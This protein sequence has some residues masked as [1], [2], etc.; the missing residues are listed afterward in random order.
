MTL[1]EAIALIDAATPLLPSAHPQHWADLGC[2]TGLFT[3]ALTHLLPLQSTVYGVD[4]NPRLRQT[5]HMIPIKA[6][7]VKD[8]LPLRDL[9]GILM[10]NSLH[11]VKDKPSLL[12]KLSACMRPGSPVLI[13]E[14]DTDQA[15]STWV[16]YPVSYASLTKLFITAGYKQVK[17]LGQRPSAYGR[18]NMYAAIALN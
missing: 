6:D 2:G 1:R 17:K 11:Y 5:A 14:Y 12:D 7:F 15:V 16:P 13:V 8:D 18:A 9:D 3:E 10:A 4:T